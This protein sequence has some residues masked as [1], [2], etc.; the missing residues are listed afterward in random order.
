[1]FFR[2]GYSLWRL[3]TIP[4][5]FSFSSCGN[6]SFAPEHACRMD[7]HLGKSLVLI[8]CLLLVGLAA[9]LRQPVTTALAEQLPISGLSSSSDTNYHYDRSNGASYNILLGESA[10]KI[11][12][13]IHNGT[14]V[15]RPGNPHG[16]SAYVCFL[17]PNIIFFV[18]LMIAD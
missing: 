8:I 2:A 11:G 15:P 13:G 16:P 9:G 1:M 5:H 14:N 17:S 18:I 12:N 7:R 3:F 6:P 4:G 10:A